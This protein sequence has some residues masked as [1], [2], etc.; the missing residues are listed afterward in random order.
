MEE[1]K[2]WADGWVNGWMEVWMD[3][4]MEG[5]VDESVSGRS[6]PFLP[7]DENLS[8]SSKF[9]CLAHSD[10]EEM[11]QSHV[12]PVLSRCL[13]LT[14]QSNFGKPSRDDV[15]IS[16]SGEGNEAKAVTFHHID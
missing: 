3:G 5:R 16:S 1:D 14:F 9:T 11:P 4:Q 10:P 15:K 12:I 8:L 2:S 7:K 13:T 6:V